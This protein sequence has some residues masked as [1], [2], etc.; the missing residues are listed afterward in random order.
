MSAPPARSAEQAATDVV[1]ET[2]QE[3]REL[4]QEDGELPVALISRGSSCSHTS[5]FPWCVTA[6]STDSSV[7][8]S[9][10]RR[11]EGRAGRVS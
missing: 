8:Y 3:V 1:Q 2:K 11:M 5:C 6:D 4:A 10:L 9:A 7:R